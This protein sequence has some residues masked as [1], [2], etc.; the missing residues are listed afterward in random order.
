[1]ERELK[2]FNAGGAFAKGDFALSVCQPITQGFNGSQRIGDHIRVKKV[3]IR[4]SLD[5]GANGEQSYSSTLRWLFLQDKRG[6]FSDVSFFNNVYDET[7]STVTPMEVFNPSNVNRFAILHDSFNILKQ[8][9]QYSVYEPVWRYVPTVSPFAWSRV[10]TFDN[11]D[12]VVAFPTVGSAL[13]NLVF[14][15][16]QSDPLDQLSG[17]YYTTSVCFEDVY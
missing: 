6:L 5:W 16:T 8:E 2:V 7:V 10:F 17:T 3:V 1:M 14:M 9:A 15:M 4:V 12:V 11:L 13:N